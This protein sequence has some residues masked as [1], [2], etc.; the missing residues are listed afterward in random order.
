MKS[1]GVLLE[2]RSEPEPNVINRSGST[3]LEPQLEDNPKDSVKKNEINDNLNRSVIARKLETYG[4][5][6]DHH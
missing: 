3:L 6:K 5:H 4:L 1:E 2:Y